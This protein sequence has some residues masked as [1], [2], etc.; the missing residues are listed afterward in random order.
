MRILFQNEP[1]YGN[2]EDSGVATSADA[3][4]LV[5]DE[6]ITPPPVG[7]NTPT[8]GTTHSKLKGT[9]ERGSPLGELEALAK[10]LAQAQGANLV[11]LV[12]VGNDA[13]PKRIRR[14]TNKPNADDGKDRGNNQPEEEI[15]DEEEDGEED[16]VDDE[17]EEEEVDPEQGE[18]GEDGLGGEGH[19]PTL[20]HLLHHRHHHHLPHQQRASSRMSNT[21]TSTI[22]QHYYPEGGWGWIIV[23]VGVLVHILTHGL[24]TAVGVLILAAGSA[25]RIESIIFT[26]W[27]GALS[28]AVALFISPITIAVCKRKSTRLT[29][30]IGGLVTA[31]GCL[32]TSFASQFHQ[33]FFSYG[34]VVG[35]GVGMTRDCST[36]MVAQYFKKRREFVEIFIVSGSGLGIAVMSSFIKSA[37]DA[38]GWRLGLQAVTGTVF[39][40]FILGTCYRSASLYHPQR[41]AILHLKNQKRKIKDKN[42]HDDRPPFFDFST[43]RSKTVRILLASTGI[44]AFGINTPIFY[45]AHEVQKDGI[46]DKV[47]ILQIYLGLAWTLGCT[48][49]GLLVVR[50]SV[51]CRIARQYLCQTAIFMCGVC[52]LAL[53]AVHGNYHGYVM[54]VWIY[55]IFC[56]GYHYSLKMYTYEKV[57][58]RNFARAWG[59]VQFAQ[60]IPIALGV[61]ISG[62]MNDSGSGTAGYYFSSGCAIVGSVLMFLIDLHRRSVSR[63][64]HTRANGTR[65]LC[66]S[67]TCPQRRKLSFSQEP[68]NEPGIITGNTAMMIGPELLIPPLSDGIVEPINGLDKPE[69]TCISEEGIADMDLPD[70]LLDDLDYVGDCITSCNKVENYLMLSEF[71]NNLSAEVPILLDKRGRRLS[72]SK[73]KALLG[74]HLGAAPGSTLLATQHHP[75]CPIEHSLGQASVAAGHPG[76]ANGL[77]LLHPHQSHHHSQ[78][79]HPHHHHH[80]H[81]PHHHQQQPANGDLGKNVSPL[82][83]KSD[84]APQNT[85]GG[86]GTGGG[87]VGVEGGKQAAGN[88]GGSSTS[89][90]SSG[91]SSSSAVTSN[92]LQPQQH[93]RLNSKWRPSQQVGFLNNRVISVIDEASV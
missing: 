38:I 65:H 8:G 84:S 93:C 48:A 58:A 18:V 30:V 23:L 87:R 32:F 59:F 7:G 68:D 74:G 21:S 75:E 49:F 86:G 73:T 55:G 28:T 17:E 44:G 60:A 63:H 22:K 91:S 36:L 33:L 50:N 34:A 40:T 67:E 31:L 66:V 6:P 82:V 69:L 81:H 51:E 61:P 70:N 53:T 16:A 35:V 56:G 42:K 72:L 19:S 24:Q 29:A 64:K 45:L 27:L 78:H 57:R 41:R 89:N 10:A 5:F 76:D 80:H 4:S 37:I 52:I 88:G 54:F 62:Y 11:Q 9:Q 2:Y 20:P 12:P 25:Y 71:E 3:H 79:H 46:G 90:N 15:G 83:T 92:T 43:L 85:I 14:R 77:A 39:I 47:M 13:K 1:V 26:G